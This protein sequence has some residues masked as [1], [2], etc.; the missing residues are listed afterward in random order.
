M[1]WLAH[2]S[3]RNSAS[4]S[5]DWEEDGSCSGESTLL[6]SVVV[7]VVV[8][9]LTAATVSATEEAEA[10]AATIK[11]TVELVLLSLFR[12]VL[13]LCITHSI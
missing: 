4:V 12:L 2:S 5:C 1:R 11:G 6:V 3:W 7:V 10:A 9:V 13:V 8:V